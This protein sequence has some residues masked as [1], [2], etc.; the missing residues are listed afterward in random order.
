M[1]GAPAAFRSVTQGSFELHTVDGQ[2]VGTLMIEQN[3]WGLSPFFRRWGV[4]AGD[5]VVIRL[6]LSERRAVIEAGDQDLLLEYQEG[7]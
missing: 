4:E 5:Y 3:M 2:P 6:N 7:E 1:L